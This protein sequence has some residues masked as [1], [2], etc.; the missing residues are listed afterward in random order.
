MLA[1]LGDLEHAGGDAG[2]VR[3]GA[4]R[5]LH[6]QGIE[7]DVGGDD[8]TMLLR[9]RT[10]VNA[11]GLHAPALARQF[12]GLDARH[13]PAGLCQGQLLHAAR[14]RA[15]QPADLPGARGRRPGRAPHAGPGRPGQ[16][17]PRCAVGGCPID[18][19]VDPARGDPSTPRCALL[20]RPADGALQP[21]YAGIRPKISGPGEPA[22][23]F[24]IDGPAVHG[25]PGLVNLF[26]IESPGLT[27]SLAMARFPASMGH[28]ALSNWKRSGGRRAPQRTAAR[29]GAGRPPCAGRSRG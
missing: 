25:V 12:Q 21:G 27:S 9:A 17:R 4:G 23:D 3:A 2:A 10:V 14:P 22:A 29:S 18:Y 28:E 26:G 1:L 7:L 5:A 15:V 24:R 19:T 6:A 13:M 16:V 20:A 11:A 8:G